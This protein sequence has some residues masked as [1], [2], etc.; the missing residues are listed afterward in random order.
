MMI[1]YEDITGCV[2]NMWA[3]RN[4]ND[5]LEL[6]S[7]TVLLNWIMQPYQPDRNGISYF[8]CDIKNLWFVAEED[9]QTVLDGDRS[10]SHLRT[11]SAVLNIFK[12]FKDKWCVLPVVFGFFYGWILWLIRGRDGRAYSCLGF[13]W[14]WRVK[15][16]A[17]WLYSSLSATLNRAPSEEHKGLSW[18]W[19]C[20]P[21]PPPPPLSLPPHFHASTLIS[22]LWLPRLSSLFSFLLLSFFLCALL[23]ALSSPSPGSHMR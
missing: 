8:Q 15:L 17:N 23:P 6:F 19:P 22:P 11:L 18:S 21:P 13:Q 20:L 4:S 3:F 9:V 10:W 1:I 5:C 2:N 7:D 14:K 12:G 16:S